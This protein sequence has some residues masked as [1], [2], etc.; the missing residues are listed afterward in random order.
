[1]R[2]L[3][4]PKHY[5]Q[6]EEI[7]DKKFPYLIQFIVIFDNEMGPEICIGDPIEYIL[8]ILN[9]SAHLSVAH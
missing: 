6:E 9:L 3:G 4:I 2:C 1:M 7:Q 8:Y 5:V